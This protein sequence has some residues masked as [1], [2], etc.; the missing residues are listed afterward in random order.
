MPLDAP[1]LVDLVLRRESPKGGLIKTTV[2]LE[3]QRSLEQILR[4]HRVRLA[5]LGMEQVGAIA[6]SAKTAEVLALVG[7][8]NYSEQDQGFNNG[9]FAYPRRGFHFEAPLVCSFSGARPHAVVRDTRH[10]PELPN[11]SRGLSSLQC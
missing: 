10:I 5:Q 4:S 6:A 7:S 11:T 8:L 2:D 3:L 9:V 1:H